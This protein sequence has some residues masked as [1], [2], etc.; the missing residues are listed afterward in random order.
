MNKEHIVNSFGTIL[1]M[2]QDR[3]VSLPPGLVKAH[4]IDVLSNETVLKPVIEVKINKVKLIYYTPQKFKWADVK[5]HFED[6]DPYETYVLIVSEP[7]TQ[8]NM[9]SIIAMHKP[10]EVHLINRLQFNITKHTLVPKHEVIRDKNVI[11]ELT[12]RYKLK[13]KMQFPIILKTDPIA[14]Y[15]GMRTGDLVRITRTSETA[16]EYV[17]YRCCL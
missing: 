2:L 5:K 14:K 6:D 7:I 16:G 13:S 3:F 11:D 8:N 15:Y 10:V 1:E 17:I 9:K 12:Q 4:M